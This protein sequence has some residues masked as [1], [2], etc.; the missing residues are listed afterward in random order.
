MVSDPA[1]VKSLLI[2]RWPGPLPRIVRAAGRSRVVPDNSASPRP[3]L[4]K[5]GLAPA[6]CR[7]LPAALA[8]RSV[9]EAGSAPLNVIPLRTKGFSPRSFVVVYKLPG[10]GNVGNM[11]CV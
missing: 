3:A 10:D 7:L 11:S 2:V 1:P 5:N 4:L 6:N 9:K 8:T